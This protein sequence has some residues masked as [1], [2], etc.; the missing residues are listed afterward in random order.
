MVSSSWWGDRTNA[1]PGTSTVGDSV[2]YGTLRP[3][4]T[5]PIGGQS[6]TAQMS[7]SDFEEGPVIP[8][9][10]TLVRP[11]LQLRPRTAWT[12]PS[13]VQSLRSAGG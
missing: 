1:A 2:R 6:V 5:A 3:P 11:G 7:T 8:P 12:P 4:H 10:V 9:C 13:G